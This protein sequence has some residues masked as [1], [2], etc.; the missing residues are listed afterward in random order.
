[1]S[2]VFKIMKHDATGAVY[3]G[4]MSDGP[5]GP[6]VTKKEQSQRKLLIVGICSAAFVVILCL[7]LKEIG[8]NN[9]ITKLVDSKAKEEATLEKLEREFLEKQYTILRP[10]LGR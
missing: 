9:G 3:D 5:L 4:C 10:T 1:M 2:K 6:A 8:Y 7:V